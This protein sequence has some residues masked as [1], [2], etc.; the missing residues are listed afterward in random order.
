VTT[1]RSK[2]NPGVM[3]SLS[4]S[5][6]LPKNDYEQGRYTGNTSHKLGDDR[7]ESPLTKQLQDRN[8]G[9]N[10]IIDYTI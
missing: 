1:K 4:K 10:M 9:K 3:R 5:K 7:K 6:L 2:V 8:R